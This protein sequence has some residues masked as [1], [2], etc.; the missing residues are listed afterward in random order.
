M[1]RTIAEIQN[2]MVES[3]QNDETLSVNLTSTS[4]T[5]IWR[6]YIYTVAVAIWILEK[7]FDTHKSDVENIILNKTP[8]WP[9]WYCI[10]ALAFQ[11]GHTLVTDSDKY[12]VEDD[13]TKIVSFAAAVETNDGYL[14]L[15]VAKVSG[16]TLQKL[17]G[18]WPNSGVSAPMGDTSGGSGEQLAFYNYMQRVKDAGVKIRFVSQDPDFLRLVIDAYFDPMVLDN[19]GKRLDGTNNTPLQD[20]INKYIESLPFNGEY[21]NM[22]LTDAMQAVDGVKIPQILSAEAY[23]GA[24]E[25]ETISAKY[26]PEAGWLQVYSG[27]ITIN[28]LPYGTNL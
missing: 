24:Y 16:T 5:A 19:E 20:A 4:K 23:W 13:T 3:V 26:N 25:W 1:A 28:W 22:A 7:L 17:T 11:Y 8:H 21:S 27:Y 12:A 9:S 2:M 14:K 15:K 6:L 10:K 18:A